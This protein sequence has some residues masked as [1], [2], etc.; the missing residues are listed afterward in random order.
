M[1]PIL[2]SPRFG[3]LRMNIMDVVEPCAKKMVEIVVESA[4]E[5]LVGKVMTHVKDVRE[6]LQQAKQT[7]LILLLARVEELDA[8]LK[9]EG[10][11]G[12]VHP[13]ATKALKTL[14]TVLS[15]VKGFIEESSKEP[16]LGQIFRGIF[17]HVKY[18]DTAAA[19]Q[20]EEVIKHYQSQIQEEIECFNAA[21]TTT[22]AA[23]V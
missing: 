5:H 13:E 3:F 1:I 4:T 15:A 19:R 17:Y 16:S 20:A 18:E 7:Q 12:S 2:G 6:S 14:D 9:S 10:A 23:E 8:L 22:C 11:R 21:I